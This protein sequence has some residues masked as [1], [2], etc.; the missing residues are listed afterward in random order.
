MASGASGFSEGG[1]TGDG[2]RYQPAGIVHKGEYVFSAPPVK[3]LGIQRLEA[4]H[5]SARRYADGGLAGK[6]L[7]SSSSVSAADRSSPRP[8]AIYVVDSDW[9]ARHPAKNSPVESQI[10]DLVKANRELIFA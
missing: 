6:E 9:Q 2:G 5:R 10:I 1:Y 8:L 4:L 7:S 3:A